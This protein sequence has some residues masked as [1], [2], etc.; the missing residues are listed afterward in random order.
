LHKLGPVG[1]QLH[2]LTSMELISLLLSGDDMVLLSSKEDELAV[3]L[4]VM[5]KISAG[6]GLRIKASKT[7][8]M[9]IPGHAK[10]GRGGDGGC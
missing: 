7:E 5:D 2:W 9:A 10:G 3:M 8:T 6:L 1:Y 4:K